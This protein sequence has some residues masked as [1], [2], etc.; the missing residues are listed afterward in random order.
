MVAKTIVDNQAHWQTESLRFTAFPVGGAAKLDESWWQAVTGQ[1]PET[2]TVQPNVL[3][4]NGPIRD[5]RYR[6]VLNCIPGRIDWVLTGNNPPN[7]APDGAFPLAGLL[8][9]ALDSF[10]ELIAPW[11]PSCPDV[12]RLAFGVVVLHPV[13]TVPEGY[14]L[15]QNYLPDLKLDADGS[16]D[17][18]YSINR[19]RPSSVGI[20][21]LLVNRLSKWGVVRIQRM[22][23]MASL[24]VGAPLLQQIELGGDFTAARLELDLSTSA[25]FTKALPRE[26]LPALWKELVGFCVE[27]TDKGDVR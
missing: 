21:G 17:F 22:R 19:P 10:Q 3:A 2:K 8:E 1:P 4:E 27:L 25:D 9:E 24:G 20:D 7:G 15:L 6:L 14:R 11:L 5:G 26:N 12:Q 23:L 13:S 18:S 16:S